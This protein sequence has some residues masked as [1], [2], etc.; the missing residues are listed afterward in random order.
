MNLVEAF[1]FV[2]LGV[3]AGGFFATRLL[4]RLWMRGM[5]LL[6]CHRCYTRI[7][8]ESNSISKFARTSCE[9]CGNVLVF[10]KGDPVGPPL[11][12]L[13]DSMS[14]EQLVTIFPLLRASQL[15]QL[16]HVVQIVN[17][18]H[19]LWV[20]SRRSTSARRSGS[21]ASTSSRCSGERHLRTSRIPSNISGAP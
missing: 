8:H 11:H 19:D 12:A 3:V 18:N 20:R 16:Q 2:L 7:Q 21:R 6:L 9:D 14:E 1:L 17:E 10:E 4:S 13:L 5:N 15:T